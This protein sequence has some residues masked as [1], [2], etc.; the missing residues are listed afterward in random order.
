M[1]SGWHDVGVLRIA[2]RNEGRAFTL[3][4]VLISGN[5]GF[6]CEKERVESD[7]CR[8]CELFYLDDARDKKEGL[9]ARL[10]GGST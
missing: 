9:T 3:L 4:R 5:L 7:F 6:T 8:A 1:K 2:G 10:K